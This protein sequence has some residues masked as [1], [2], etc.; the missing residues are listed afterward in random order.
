ME[1]IRQFWWLLPLVLSLGGILTWLS[2][3]QWGFLAGSV[4]AWPFSYAMWRR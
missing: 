3:G 4:L 2:L 1:A